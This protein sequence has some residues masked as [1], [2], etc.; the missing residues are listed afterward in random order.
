[1]IIGTPSGDAAVNV[2]ARQPSLTAFGGWRTD[3]FTN[4]AMT[5]EK[6]AGI[7]AWGAGTTLIAW[8]AGT[9]PLRTYDHSSGSPIEVGAMPTAILLREQPNADLPAEQFWT[10]VLLHLLNRSNAFLAKIRDPA[11]GRVVELF[12][13]HP[14]RCWAFRDDNGKKWIRVTSLTGTGP[15]TYDYYDHDQILHIVGP[16][17]GDGIMGDSL[18]A[19]Y[20]Q[21]LAVAYAASEFQQRVYAQGTIQSGILKAPENISS[22]PRER[23]K[24]LAE[25]WRTRYTGGTNAHG[26]I[27]LEPGWDYEPISLSPEDQQFVAQMEHSVSEIASW[28]HLPASMLN[29]GTSSEPYQNAETHDLRVTKWAM[30]PWT[31]WIEASLRCDRD[32]FG[33]AWRP[34]F[35]YDELLRTDAKTRSEIADTRVKGSTW[36]PDE[37]RAREGEPPRSDELGSKF[38]DELAADGISRAGTSVSKDTKGSTDAPAG[39][40][41]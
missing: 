19:T 38:T 12:A 13:L 20:R 22:L 18:V 28:L 32:L 34:R 4:E 8:G 10:M 39:T 33:G 1:M 36:T 41:G 11:T 2:S 31:T 37:A 9:L 30:R 3:T 29:G 24:E 16:T 21:R 15:A 26:V 35:D 25:D 17:S 40:A 5:L 27:I 6:S 14:D 23:K 7:S